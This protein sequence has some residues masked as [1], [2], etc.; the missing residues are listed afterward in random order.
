MLHAFLA[1]CDSRYNAQLGLLGE[2]YKTPGYSSHLKDVKTVHSTRASLDYAL[3][4]LQAGRDDRRAAR[5]VAATVT[6]Q[7]TDP[8]SETYGA[9]PW[10]LEEPLAQMN[11]PDLNWAD[12]LGARLAQIALEHAAQLTPELQ[13]QILGALGHAAWAIFRR[14]VSLGYTNI[15][16]MGAGVCALAGEIMAQPPLLEYG[17]RKLQ[18]VVARAQQTGGLSE[19]NSPTYTLVVLWE[20]ERILQ[21]VRDEQSRQAA[22]TL[23]RLTWQS[24]AEHFHPATQ[25]WSG[26][27]SRAYSNHLQP[28]AVSY[29]AEQTGVALQAHP[30]Q[31]NWGRNE[32]VRHLPCPPEFIPLF[33]QPRTGEVRRCFAQ[34]E[35]KEHWV[36][37]TTWMD[38]TA[39]LGTVNRDTLRDQRRA[40]LGY[41]KTAR[42]PAVVLRARF[43]KDGRDFASAFLRNAQNGPR[44][45]SLLSILTNQ[46]D[47]YAFD[48]PADGLF[49]ASD[50]R[51]RFELSGRGVE[52]A[53]LSDALYELRA[54]DRRALIHALPGCFGEHLLRW[55]LGHS[56]GAVF[57]EGVCYHGEEQKFDLSR[58]EQVVIAAG[59]ELLEVN[60]APSEVPQLERE[61]GKLR[62]CWPRHHLELQAPIEPEF[63]PY[64][65]N[66]AK[67]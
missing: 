59:L 56:E 19:Y 31:K 45:L 5:L 27:H 30:H 7:D 46:G 39:T 8:L 26:P 12:F 36:W 15:A 35:I 25:Q 43:L 62:C 2:C 67:V 41:W 29:L 23:R 64:L 22:E 42:D 63:Y 48:R 55:E 14:N 38:E 66:P 52:A 13:Q 11:P 61:A 50:F 57:V 10:F 1:S 34:R 44:V 16:V 47:V 33:R 54:G 24:I 3:A 9:W 17:R 58:L 32:A 37:G 18:A 51:V 40:L 20:C 49:A 53:Q 60:V 28:D 21:L 65:L 4:L 6:L